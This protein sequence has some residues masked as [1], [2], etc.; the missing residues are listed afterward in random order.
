MN[1]ANKS[2]IDTNLK[3]VRLKITPTTIVFKTNEVDGP[4][5]ASDGK[6]RACDCEATLF[7]QNF[8]NHAFCMVQETSDCVGVEA[9]KILARA[10]GALFLK[11][12]E[13]RLSELTIH[14]SDVL[15]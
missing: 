1:S 14:T 13:A 2:C 11:I 5:G 10:A 7:G 15:D 12:R 9:Q 8:P 6:A 3:E 4:G